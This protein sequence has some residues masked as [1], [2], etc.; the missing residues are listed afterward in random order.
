MKINSSKFWEAIIESKGVCPFS[1]CNK[2]CEARTEFLCTYS[3]AYKE[4]LKKID[5]I[6]LDRM[7]D[8]INNTYGQRKIL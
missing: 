2:K 4:A 8:I 5:F 3:Y 1:S 6:K 7:I